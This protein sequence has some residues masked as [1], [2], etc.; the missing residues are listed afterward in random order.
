M[1]ATDLN[2]TEFVGAINPDSRLNV[3]FFSKPVQNNFLTEKEGRPIFEDRD[4]IRI[5]T[6]GDN[7]N[8]I[9]T[10]A[11]KSHQN[12]FPRQWALYQN[13]KESED[14]IGTP[15][16]AWNLITPA[17]A[18]EFKALKFFTVE[19]IANASDQQI[20]NIGMK[21]GMSPY[22]LRDKAK[23]YLAASRDQ[24]LA[25]NREQELEDTKRQLAE[26]KAQLDAL[27]PK[28]TLTL[29]KKDK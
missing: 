17:Q 1:L 9:E 14:Q 3:Q 7:L 23:L 16:K 24:A 2:N 19:N 21:G 29:P 5:F 4:Y 12:R 26:M 22:A 11:D 8:I 6:P 18:E 20:Q 28:K 15:L 13:N 25:T 10:F 27:T